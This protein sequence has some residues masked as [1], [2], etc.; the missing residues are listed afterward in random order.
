MAEWLPAWIENSVQ[1]RV[2]LADSFHTGIGSFVPTP[3]PG[4][5]GG[6]QCL[7]ACSSTVGIEV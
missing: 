6:P 4:V 1:T 5:T 3:Q 7:R 2:L